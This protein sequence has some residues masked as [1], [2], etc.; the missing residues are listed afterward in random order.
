MVS[1]TIVHF[2]NN[3][4]NWVMLDLPLAVII[5]YYSRLLYCRLHG[6]VLIR[7]LS[8]SRSKTIQDFHQ[9][10]LTAIKCVLCFYL[11]RKLWLLSTDTHFTSSLND[12]WHLSSHAAVFD[13]LLFFETW[14][15]QFWSKVSGKCCPQD[16]YEQQSS[17]FQHVTLICCCTSNEIR[18]L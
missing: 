18:S 14:I 4:T 17:I 10:S 8:S 13:L 3:K 1:W 5:N 7:S 15:S 12:S 16:H 11:E 6:G 9:D 2:V